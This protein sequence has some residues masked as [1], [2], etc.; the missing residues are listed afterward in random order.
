MP[1]VC[2]VCGEEGETMEHALFSCY[3]ASQVSR[4]AS[5]GILFTHVVDYVD[6]FLDLIRPAAAHPYRTFIAYLVYHL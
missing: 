5:F 2:Q 4:L 3:R 1:S 6:T